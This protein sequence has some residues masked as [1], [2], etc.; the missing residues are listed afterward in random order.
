MTGVQ[1]CALPIS[2]DSTGAKLNVEVQRADKGA[3]RKRA[4]Y[5]SS[6]MDA[7]FLKKGEDLASLSAILLEWKSDEKFTSYRV[8]V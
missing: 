2:T 5:N 6:M 3:G 8:D 7:N 4:R 1:T